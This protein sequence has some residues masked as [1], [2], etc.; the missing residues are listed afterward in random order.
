MK[1][2]SWCSICSKQQT[3][4]SEDD[5]YS[6][7]ASLVSRGCPFNRC[8]TRERAMAKVLFDIH[9]RDHLNGLSI[10]EAAPA[11]RG[12]SLY[13]ADLDSPNYVCSGYFKDKPFGIGVG[14]FI[15]QDLQRQTFGDQVFDLVLHLDVLEHLF[16]PFKALGEIYRTLK[17]GGRCIFTVPTYPELIKSKRVAGLSEGGEI[18]Y[19]EKAEYHGNPQ[20]PDNGS[21]VTWKYGYDLPLLI[22]R[23]TKFDVEVRRWQ[24]RSSAICG[25]MTE[26]YIC[27]RPHE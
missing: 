24:D 23:F 5:Y 10:H 19:I 11:W 6:C 2:E 9:G 22:S 1:M 12:L 25:P 7:R 18:F 21:L 17:A 15:N 16:E 3:F 13:L 27:T 20:D 4:S 14:R 8:V 26:V